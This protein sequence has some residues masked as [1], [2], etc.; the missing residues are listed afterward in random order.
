EKDLTLLF[1]KNLGQRVCFS[2]RRHAQGL[3]GQ[4]EHP[5]PI[6]QSVDSLFEI[7]F[8]SLFMD[9]EAIEIRVDFLS[10]DVMRSAIELDG[11]LSDTSAIVSDEAFAVLSQCCFFNELMVVD[12]ELGH[13]VTCLLH[14]GVEIILFEAHKFLILV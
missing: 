12:F 6:P 14:N 7:S 9:A 8:R 13:G 10:G 11:D 3:P 4:V 5:E 2:D 1:R